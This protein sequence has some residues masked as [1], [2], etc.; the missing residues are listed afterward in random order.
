[1]PPD[2]A[3]GLAA[4]EPI[5]DNTP[6]FDLCALRPRGR[7]ERTLNEMRGFDASLFRVVNRDLSGLFSTLGNALAGIFRRPIG[8]VKGFFAAIRC[9]DRNG[10][11]ALVYMGNGAI[12]CF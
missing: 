9:F 3:T 11:R 1:M 2:P 5:V 7:L 10:L 8:Q 12:G 4:Q 6:T